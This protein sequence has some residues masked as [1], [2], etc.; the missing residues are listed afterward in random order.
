MDWEIREAAFSLERACRS[1]ELPSARALS[2]PS[3]SLAVSRHGHRAFGDVAATIA[4]G[5]EGGGE[6]A[7][8]PSLQLQVAISSSWAS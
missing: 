6:Q 1:F 5:V 2:H 8:P 4:G 3:S 7:V